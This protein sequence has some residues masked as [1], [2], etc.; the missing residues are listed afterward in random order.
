VEDGLQTI[1]NIFLGLKLMLSILSPA[2]KLNFDKLTRN[3]EA[4]TPRFLINATNLA[5]IAAE[6]S[7]QQLSDLMKISPKLAE[8]NRERFKNFSD[9]PT[10]DQVKQAAFAFSGDTYIGLGVDKINPN[11]DQFFQKN[12]RILSG[13]Y[14]LLRPFDEIQP[15]RLEMGSKLKNPKGNNLYAFWG[16]RIVQELETDIK[17]HEHKNI[18]NLASEEYFK[19]VKTQQLNMKIITP[20]FFEIK[21]GQRKIVSFYAKKARG[22]MARFIVNN[23]ITKPNEIK[24][25]DLNS[26]KFDN[27]NSDDNTYIFT[28]KIKN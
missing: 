27:L 28:R 14:G 22:L 15:Y 10:K 6:L 8:L 16:H 13:L 20:K 2:K 18:I 12:I 17:N 19:V 24:L 21:S 1:N 3:C 25:F 5:N 11:N 4:S 9:N 7:S 23:K 26:Y